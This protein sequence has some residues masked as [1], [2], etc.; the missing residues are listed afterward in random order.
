[1]I[2]YAQTAI[3]ASRTIKE[4]GAPFVLTRVVN[5]EYDTSTGT[6]EGG[7]RR[8]DGHAIR[9]D[10]SS[11]DID[12]ESILATD[13][14]FMVS[15]HTASGAA[16]EAPK[17][18]DRALFDGKWTSVVSCKALKPAHTAIYFIVQTRG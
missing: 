12:G 1:M 13:T 11:R 10:Y 2:D 18:G 16:M 4:N 3:A 17:E 8:W 15:V 6:V 9:S 5:A 14:R 7:N